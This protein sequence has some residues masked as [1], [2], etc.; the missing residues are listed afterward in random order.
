VLQHGKAPGTLPID[1]MQGNARRGQPRRIAR[2]HGI[3]LP[4][5]LLVRSPT[6]CIDPEL[7]SMPAR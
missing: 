1:R 5:S 3:E 6:N 4:L 2:Q 7:F